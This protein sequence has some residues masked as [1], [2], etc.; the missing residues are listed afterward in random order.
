MPLSYC[1]HQKQLSTQRE[2]DKG[3]SSPNFSHP[4]GQE[5]KW[6][7]YLMVSLLRHCCNNWTNTY[8][9]KMSYFFPAQEENDSNL[10]IIPSKC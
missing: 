8:W 1:E 2:S 3:F 5:R 4:P 9:T 7:S 6:H 10:N